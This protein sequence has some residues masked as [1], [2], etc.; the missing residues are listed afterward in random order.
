MMNKVKGDR[1]IGHDMLALLF[2][3]TSVYTNIPSCRRDESKK[4]KV[5]RQKNFN[6][7]K[8]VY[9]QKTRTDLIVAHTRLKI[10]ATFM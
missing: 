8:I 2:N 5:M 4:V 10:G 3:F 9:T 7:H 6:L 1:V